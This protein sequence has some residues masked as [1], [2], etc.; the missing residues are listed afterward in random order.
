MPSKFD[1]IYPSLSALG[2]DALKAA[3][4]REKGFSIAAR[5]NEDNFRTAI[6]DAVSDF[7]NM[8]L[9][10]FKFALFVYSRFLH[11]SFARDFNYVKGGKSASQIWS[12]ALN[13]KFVPEVAAAFKSG[14]CGI[15]DSNPESCGS[16]SGID[17]TCFFMN[18]NTK[19]PSSR[20]LRAMPFGKYNADA[21]SYSPSSFRS[22]IPEIKTL[23]LAYEQKIIPVRRL[24]SAV[25][26]ILRYKHPFQLLAQ[27]M[28][29][30][31]KGEYYSEQ[32]ISSPSELTGERPD[33]G[34]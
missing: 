3:I 33:D 25:G 13:W 12:V 6:S 24:N 1:E 30:A 27:N 14:S 7:Q 11:D 29:G 10:K 32:D 9:A 21:Q 28:L 22:N 31:A 15:I 5:F 16:L 20:S 26:K 19:K 18:R 23:L 34:K 2:A 4:R 8:S 17:W